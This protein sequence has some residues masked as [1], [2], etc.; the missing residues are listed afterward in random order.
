MKLEFL[1]EAQAEFCAAAV[2]YEEKEQGLGKRFGVEVEDVCSAIVEQALAAGGRGAGG[3]AVAGTGLAA[4]S[5][6][7]AD[8]GAALRQEHVGLILDGKMR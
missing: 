3:G 5:R 1:A 7:G 6:A 8:R 4:G 2:Y